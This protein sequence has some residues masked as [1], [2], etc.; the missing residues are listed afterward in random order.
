MKPLMGLRK[1]G[2]KELSKTKVLNMACNTC[3][4]LRLPI[5]ISYFSSLYS[6]CSSYTGLL[7]W[8][9]VSWSFFL[10]RISPWHHLDFSLSSCSY[11]STV[12]ILVRMTLTTLLKLHMVPP[13]SLVDIS[14]YLLTCCIIY[15]Y[16]NLILFYQLLID[17]FKLSMYTKTFQESNVMPHRKC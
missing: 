1:N 7:A 5:S 13:T 3:S 11:S 12:I 6:C 8:K 2:K 16:I 15:S 9:S 10:L 14:D 4:G 17:K